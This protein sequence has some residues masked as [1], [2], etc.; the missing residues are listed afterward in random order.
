[1]SKQ[2]PGSSVNQQRQSSYGPINSSQTNSH[3]KQSSRDFQ[4]SS[5]QMNN[6]ISSKRSSNS[7]MGMTGTSA[8]KS[9]TNL[10]Q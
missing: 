8:S 3:L 6:Q 9:T 7:A 5:I 2:M 10:T 1:M 4:K